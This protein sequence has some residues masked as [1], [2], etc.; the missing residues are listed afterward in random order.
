MSRELFKKQDRELVIF[1]GINEM[2]KILD[3]IMGKYIILASR[4]D[5]VKRYFVRYTSAPLIIQFE[6][7][8]GNLVNINWETD[9]QVVSL[10]EYIKMSG[11]ANP[12]VIL[13]QG[14]L[15]L[16]NPIIR[17]IIP[18][19]TYIN[20]MYSQLSAI[21]SG[22]NLNDLISQFI[23][24]NQCALINN[25]KRVDILKN[26]GSASDSII[27][28]GDLPS[29]SIKR[30]GS[31]PIATK[32]VFP[33]INGRNLLKN[34]LRVEQQIYEYIVNPMLENRYTPH[35]VPYLAT[36]RCT[37]ATLLANFKKHEDVTLFE[38]LK[39]VIRGN[40]LGNYI[41]DLSNLSIL[42]LY[43][44]RDWDVLLSLLILQSSKEWLLISFLSMISSISCFK[45]YILLNALNS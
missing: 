14:N 37:T 29:P 26:K 33:Y 39:N 36:I 21:D 8:S 43:Q 12:T 19:G 32:I 5:V 18:I 25:M 23:T 11:K 1:N 20:S 35:L 40:S 6:M 3:K 34:A 16:F 9:L 44:S 22:L 17:E 2:E 41:Y 10:T 13:D 45:S 38:L 15:T 7:E 4:A 24:T 42:V 27:I 28:F 30:A 31:I